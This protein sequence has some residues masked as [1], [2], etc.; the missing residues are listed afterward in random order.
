ML[1]NNNFWYDQAA[2]ATAEITEELGGAFVMTREELIDELKRQ[3]D[4]LTNC[5][6]RVF[7][8]LT[9]SLSRYGLTSRGFIPA[10]SDPLLIFR[11]E[12]SEELAREIV[13]ENG[14]TAAS[15][16]VMLDMAVS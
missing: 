7:E 11:V 1:H 8:H 12:I 9:C 15:E 2:K 14:L 5:P 6:E 16:I 3:D 4:N 13:A 10:C